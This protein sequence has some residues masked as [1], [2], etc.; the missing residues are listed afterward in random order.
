MQHGIKRKKIARIMFYIGIV[1]SLFGS[2]FLLF[3]Y[4]SI[5]GLQA[6]GSFFLLIIG[7]L[8]VFFAV[9]LRRKSLYL[10]FAAFFTLVGLFLLFKVCGVI[11]LSLKQS[12]PLLSVFT[13]IA[14][15]LADIHQ[16]DKIY[17]IYL[18]PS[19][20][21]IVLGCF[22]LLFS[23]KIASFSFRQFV[24]DWCPVIV[25][26]SGVMLILFSISSSKG[27]NSKERM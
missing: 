8:C 7:G 9:K 4:T 12:W 15:L 18:I 27:S 24:L 1:L 3:N 26:V 22:L 10:F 19:I 5:T 21:L 13:G 23:L 14:L 20:A 25:V 2:V 16:Y 17:R 6:I 11:P